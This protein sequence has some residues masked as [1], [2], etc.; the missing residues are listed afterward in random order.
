MPLQELLASLSSSAAAML[1]LVR[2]RVADS[3]GQQ[4]SAVLHA[5]ALRNAIGADAFMFSV[6]LEG[7]HAR[8]NGEVGRERSSTLPAQNILRQLLTPL[9]LPSITCSLLIGG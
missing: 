7:A 3:I 9:P 4:C 1:H 2:E 6:K 5:V 8:T